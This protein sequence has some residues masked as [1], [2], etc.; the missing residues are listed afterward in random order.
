MVDR[1]RRSTLDSRRH[2]P[3][4]YSYAALH[5]DAAQRLAHCIP[6]HVPRAVRRI[7]INHSGARAATESRIDT[8]PLPP[9][10]VVQAIYRVHGP[11]RA[12][13]IDFCQSG[14]CAAAEWRLH[15]PGACDL[16]LGSVRAVEQDGR[17]GQCEMGVGA[18]FQQVAYWRLISHWSAWEWTR[19]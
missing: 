14:D 4:R 2:R 17:A 13:D 7:A 12:R 5:L 3:C 6:D 9:K 10:L 11:D 8:H 15:E 19:F 18:V 16:L 1:L